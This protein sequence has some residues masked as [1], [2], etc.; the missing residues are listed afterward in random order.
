MNSYMMSYF[1]N[2]NLNF[3]PLMQNFNVPP[4]NNLFNPSQNLPA[5]NPFQYP[6]KK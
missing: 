3:N 5:V 6:F 2:P 4:N 1:S